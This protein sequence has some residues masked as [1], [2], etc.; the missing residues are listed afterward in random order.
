MARWRPRRQKCRCPI[1]RALTL[2]TRA[3]YRLIG[4]RH[5]GVDD[6][7]V[8][9]G[10]PLF[11]I[12]VQLPDMVY[13]NFT[14]CP[15][16][17][18]KVKSFNADEIKALPGVLDAFA[19]EGTGK[20]TEVM[21]GV[22]IIAKDTWSAFQAKNKLKVDWDESEA[23]KDSTSQFSAEREK[24]GAR[25]SRTKPDTNVGDVDKAFAQGRQDGGSLL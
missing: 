21:P 19:V 25:T 23:S 15:A 8:V 2:K 6:P 4:K 13:A 14:K 10:Q 16:V 17:G 18:G 12:D 9:T 1:P 22:A 20:P 7:K 5:R 24:A 3:E 11:G